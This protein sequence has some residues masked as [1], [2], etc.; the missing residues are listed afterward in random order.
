[1]Q[2]RAINKRVLLPHGAGQLRLAAG[3]LWLAA[4]QLLNRSWAAGAARAARKLKRLAIRPSVFCFIGQQ[5]LKIE[6]KCYFKHT[7]FV[8]S[9]TTGYV[10]ACTGKGVARQ[11]QAATIIRLYVKSFYRHLPFR[12]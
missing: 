6:F 12:I 11:P 5:N 3:K 10:R 7:T 8:H 4:G 1:M 9:K 2:P